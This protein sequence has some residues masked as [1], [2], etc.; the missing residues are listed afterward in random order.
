MFKK[1]HFISI[2][3][4]VMH[5]LAIALAR[6]GHRVTGSDDEI[7]EPAYSTLKKH[8]LLPEKN[9]W[10]PSR[11][12]S[13]LD[14]VI[15]G[16]HAKKDNPELNKALK[17]GLPL[18]S[19]P[20]FIY[21]I[22]K[23]KPRIVVAGSHGKTTV[24][25]MLLHIFKEAGHT[26]NFLVGARLKGYE[27][28]V[29]VD[30]EAELAIFEGDEYLASALKPV[31]KFLFYKA[32]IAIITGIAWDHINVF[33][34]FDLYLEQFRKLI[35]SIPPQGT[36]IY[37]QSDKVLAE[38]V[39]Q[40]DAPCKRVPY[41]SPPCKAKSDGIHFELDQE[42]CVLPM[43]GIHNASNY[44]SAALAAKEYGLDARLIAEAASRFPGPSRR[45]EIVEK[46][47]HLTLIDDFAHAPSKVRASVAAVRLHYPRHHFIAVLELH[48]FSSLRPEFLK[49]YKDS[50]READDAFVYLNPEALKK[51]GAGVD[52]E[53][54]FRSF[55]F[56]G[57][58]VS[59][60]ISKIQKAVK[61]KIK[62]NT[63]I[64]LMS[65]GH[66]GGKDWHDL[67]TF[68]AARKMGT[69]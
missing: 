14:A 68:A 41:I 66:W 30:S 10:F 7:Y 16:M 25:S 48:T 2:G 20:E 61:N 45:L 29:N 34:S 39:E 6:A 38:L 37:N 3:G 51:K 35:R 53:M 46:S 50:L 4:S 44:M 26:C 13:G 28:M 59:Q 60:E 17:L 15:L 19:F 9:G 24:T 31:P 58:I 23:E 27:T 33:P 56:P 1:Y 21:E 40:T 52:E 57:L 8:G 12:H 69:I 5:N 22:A 42:E 36:L 49:E 54:I 65:S 67:A 64:L 47:E 18:Y 32:D 63:V 43:M 55:A 11:I 62:K